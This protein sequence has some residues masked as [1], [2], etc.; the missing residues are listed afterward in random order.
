MIQ[1]IIPKTRFLQRTERGLQ[2]ANSQSDTDKNMVI[3]KRRFNII[4]IFNTGLI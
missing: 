3:K 4:F 1:R 2:C